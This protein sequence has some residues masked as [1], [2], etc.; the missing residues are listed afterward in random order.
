MKKVGESLRKALKAEMLILARNDRDD[1]EAA[2]AL[3][4]AANER[5]GYPRA[6]DAI[7]NGDHVDYQ[8]ILD[9]VITANKRF[10]KDV[11]L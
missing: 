9:R 2:K 1:F 3:V 6:R 11:D 10:A 5:L 8:A 4:K 7:A